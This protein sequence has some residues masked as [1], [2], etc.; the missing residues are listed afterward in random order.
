MIK[1]RMISFPEIE[2]FR[3]IVKYVSDRVRYSGKDEYN[4]PIFDLSKK[5]PILT[6]NGTVKLH[7]T[8]SGITL[9]KNG[10]MY[11]QSREHI[12]TIDNDNAG[13]AFFVESHK[14]EIKKLFEQ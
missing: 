6:F 9:T 8:N 12:I 13:F 10:D 7:G 14:T 11:A 3:N 5:L 4:N 2:Q 1:R